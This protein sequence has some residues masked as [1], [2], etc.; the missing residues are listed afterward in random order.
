MA[1]WVDDL[2]RT[3]RVIKRQ[4]G[5]LPLGGVEGKNGANRLVCDR[6]DVCIS[7]IESGPRDHMSQPGSLFDAA[8]RSDR[9][10][11]KKLEARKQVVGF[12][13]SRIKRC[14]AKASAGMTIG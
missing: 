3:R 1:A 12:I 4:G 9:D 7:G 5:L 14:P 6:R 10:S 13:A 2:Y 8:Q 11:V